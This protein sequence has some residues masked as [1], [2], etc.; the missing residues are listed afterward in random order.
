MIPSTDDTVLD[1]YSS[2]LRLC[3]ETILLA[4]GRV[5]SHLPYQ[6]RFTPYFA[7]NGSEVMTGNF[8]S[9]AWATSNRSKG[10]RW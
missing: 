1:F 7:N 3:V 9:I 6:I 8:S 4:I 5:A 10:S 2:S